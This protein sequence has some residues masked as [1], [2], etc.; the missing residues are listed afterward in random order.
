LFSELK[1]KAIPTKANLI[2]IMIAD[3]FQQVR[4]LI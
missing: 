4:L 3:N 1:I 2:Y